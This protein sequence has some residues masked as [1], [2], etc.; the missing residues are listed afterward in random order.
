MARKGEVSIKEICATLG[1]SRRRRYRAT[2]KADQAAAEALEPK[3]PGRKGKSRYE[4]AIVDLNGQIAELNKQL[5]HWKTKYEL[6]KAFLDLK[7]KSTGGS[8][9]TRHPRTRKKTTMQDAQASEEVEISAYELLCWA[10]I[11]TRMGS[12]HDGR[13]PRRAG[14]VA[15]PLVGQ[16]AD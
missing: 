13:G 14:S 8:P 11:A 15:D 3:K 12:R 9:W 2:H 16:P 1:V 4:Q 7:R 10:G 6:A 5:E